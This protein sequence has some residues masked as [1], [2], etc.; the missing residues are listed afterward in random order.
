M[1]AAVTTDAH[2]FEIVELPDPTPDV[3][4]LVIRVTACG[5][6]G[7]D[8]KAQPSRLRA[9]CWGTSSAARSSQ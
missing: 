8:I 1:R 7:S 5:V 4:Q 3:D 2:G 6:C 9:W